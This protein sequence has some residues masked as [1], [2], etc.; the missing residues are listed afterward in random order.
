MIIIDFYGAL[1]GQ[2]KRWD[3]RICSQG[4]Y[5]EGQPNLSKIR[6]HLFSDLV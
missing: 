3:S 2:K 6:Q 4:D 5:F 1:E